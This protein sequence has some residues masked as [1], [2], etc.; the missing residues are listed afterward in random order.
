M[1]VIISENFPINLDR[2]RNYVEIVTR[3]LNAR[4][5]LCHSRRRGNYRR[6]ACTSRRILTERGPIDAKLHARLASMRIN[7]QMLNRRERE[8]IPANIEAGTRV[9]KSIPPEC[10]KAFSAASTREGRD[11]SISRF[12]AVLSMIT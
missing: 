1:I 12:L 2:G 7:L 5:P 11:L 8:R 4:R 6:T 10:E 9:P 3:H